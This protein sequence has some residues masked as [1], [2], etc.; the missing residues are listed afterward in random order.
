MPLHS[1]ATLLLVVATLK[2]EQP[3]PGVAVNEQV[4]GSMTQMVFDNVTG[5]LQAFFSVK[6]TE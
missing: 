3:E 1:G 2:G 6:P 5:S 4:G